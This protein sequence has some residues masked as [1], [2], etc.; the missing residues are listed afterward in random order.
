MLAGRSGAAASLKEQ[1]V[2]TDEAVR[3]FQ[4]LSDVSED[5]APQEV[6]DA[7]SGARAAIA[8]LDAQRSLVDGGDDDQQQAVYDYYT[9]LIS[10]DLDLFR[11]KEMISRSDALLARGWAD[12]SLSAREF[13]DFRQVVSAQ[14]PT[15]SSSVVPYLPDDE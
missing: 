3:Q 10:V 13:A 8:R 2:R 4:T 5:G 14:Q 1:R 12:G 11:V 9:D 15:Y 7:V 6:L